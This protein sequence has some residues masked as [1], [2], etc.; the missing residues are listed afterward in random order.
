MKNIYLAGP[1]VFF[2]NSEETFARIEKG[3]SE[4]GMCGVRPAAPIDSVTQEPILGKK[5]AQF[6]Y[7]NN[8]RRIVDCDGVLADLRPFR[9][10][11]EPDSGTVFEVGYAVALGKPVAAVIP[12][13]RSLGAKIREAH[14]V[15]DR[16]HPCGEQMDQEYG[17]L[18]EDFG[19][20][21]NLMLSESCAVFTNVADAIQW[22]SAQ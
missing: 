12:D 7:Q 18:I 11:T 22:L 5:G 1:I 13:A 2:E 9:G 4:V 21:L 19:G 6:L 8:T 17:M 3:L 14:G 20:P 10:A 15:M 16:P